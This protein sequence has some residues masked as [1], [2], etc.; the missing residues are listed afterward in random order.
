MRNSTS[1]CA[2]KEGIINEGIINEELWHATSG[3][4]RGQDENRVT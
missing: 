2:E 1:S 3:E 4:E